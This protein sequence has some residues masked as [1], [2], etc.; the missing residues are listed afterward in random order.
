MNNFA[1]VNLHQ[2]AR[3]FADACGQVMCPSTDRK[4]KKIVHLPFLNDILAVIEMAVG[5][6]DDLLAR[7]NGFRSMLDK[8]MFSLCCGRC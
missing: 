6:D 5:A 8:V 3:D 7:K 2:K 1:T 4:P